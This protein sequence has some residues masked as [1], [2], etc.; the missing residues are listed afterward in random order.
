M[1]QANSFRRPTAATSPEGGGLEN[2]AR[3]RRMVGVDALGDPHKNEERTAHI[4]EKSQHISGFL[5]GEDEARSRPP[6]LREVAREA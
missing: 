1:Y 3:R 5:S 4:T 2:E 6:S